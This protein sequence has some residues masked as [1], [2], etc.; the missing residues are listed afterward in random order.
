MLLQMLERL[1]FGFE[2]SQDTNCRRVGFA[3]LLLVRHVDEAKLLFVRLEIERL[4]VLV[5]G[6]SG[7]VCAGRDDSLRALRVVVLRVGTCQVGSCA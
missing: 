3:L 7:Q 5:D 2:A 4:A 6:S 1:F